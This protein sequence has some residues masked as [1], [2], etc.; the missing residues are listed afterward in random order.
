[1]KC[2][3]FYLN[4]K[5]SIDKQCCS[6][7]QIQ[8]CLTTRKPAP[9]GSESKSNVNNIFRWSRLRH[10]YTDIAIPNDSKMQP[11]KSK[12]KF[13]FPSNVAFLAKLRKRYELLRFKKDIFHAT[14]SYTEPLKR[15]KMLF[16]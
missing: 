14:C 6:A 4:S 15:Q 1:M 13:H 16:F 8:R 12:V 5:N 11:I 3:N 2:L 7:T 10:H 9:P